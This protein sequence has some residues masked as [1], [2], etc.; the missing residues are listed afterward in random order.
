MDGEVLAGCEMQKI[1]L[2]FLAFFPVVAIS[3][4]YPHVGRKDR[5]K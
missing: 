4:I 2:V 5:Y 3:Q 1:T